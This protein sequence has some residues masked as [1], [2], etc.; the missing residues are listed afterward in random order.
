M[1]KKALLHPPCPKRAGT[2]SFPS[3]VLGSPQSS[4]YPPREGAR[5]GA[6]GVGGCSRY[7]SGSFSP[8]ALLDDLFEPSVH[9]MSHTN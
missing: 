9:S 4:T 5:L 6:L 2:R 3:F 1:L 8:A 7:A